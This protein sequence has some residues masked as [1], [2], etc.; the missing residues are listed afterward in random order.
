ML[1]TAA[2]PSPRL[3][4]TPGGRCVSSMDCFEFDHRPILPD[5]EH[6]ALVIGGQEDSVIPAHIHRKMSDLI[7]NS[8]LNLYP[9]HGHG[10]DQE[11][12]NYERNGRCLHTLYPI[13]TRGSL[14]CGLVNARG[15]DN[16]VSV[17]IAAF[18]YPSLVI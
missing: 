17:I 4:L 11:N 15:R 9:G 13:C 16:E 12:P 1:R 3:A 7:P 18:G 14:P 8:H 2:P 10:N 6:P 5:I